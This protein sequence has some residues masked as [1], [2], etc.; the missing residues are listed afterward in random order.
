MSATFQLLHEMRSNWRTG[1]QFIPRIAVHCKTCGGA[2]TV[3]SLDRAQRFV[4]RHCG[5]EER[6]PNNFI[7]KFEKDY[8]RAF[9]E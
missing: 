5:I 2:E 7:T 4:F 9:G 1:P 3:Y 8:R 6:I